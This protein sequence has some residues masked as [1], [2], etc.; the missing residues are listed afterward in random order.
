M[1]GALIAPFSVCAVYIT[2][3][4]SGGHLNPAVTL[5][6][7]VSRHLSILR[8]IAYIICQIAGACFGSLLVVSDAHSL[9]RNSCNTAF[10]TLSQDVMLCRVPAS[11]LVCI[12]EAVLLAVH[13]CMLVVQRC[14]SK[15][16]CT[17][18]CAQ[19]M[20]TALLVSCIDQMRSIVG[21]DICTHASCC[22][23]QKA[24]C[25]VYLQRL[26]YVWVVPCVMSSQMSVHAH[27]A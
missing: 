21:P 2:A 14:L 25:L 23:V 15:A 20:H 26:T 1:C 13:N 5:A 8:G 7:V 24:A 6:A 17:S 27:H 3:N 16:P 9:I 11:V 4:I 22:C 18:Q 12:T 10:T 19:P